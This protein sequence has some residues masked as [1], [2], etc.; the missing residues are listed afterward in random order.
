[1]YRGHDDSAGEESYQLTS[2]HFVVAVGLRTTSRRGKDGDTQF[3]AHTN[4]ET[5]R[6]QHTHILLLVQGVAYRKRRTSIRR[7]ENNE[8]SLFKLLSHVVFWNKLSA[9]SIANDI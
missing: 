5:S 9:L 7:R 1:M 6:A 3:T 4:L 2:S 8:K